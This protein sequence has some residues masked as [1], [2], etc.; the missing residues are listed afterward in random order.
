MTWWALVLLFLAAW[1][2]ACLVVVLFIA[3]AAELARRVELI[4][5]GHNAKGRP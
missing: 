4:E 3:G 5:R 2:A 1:L